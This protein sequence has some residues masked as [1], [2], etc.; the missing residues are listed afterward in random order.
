MNPMLPMSPMLTNDPDL[1]NK[2]N[3][4]SPFN[5][6]IFT[7]L[8]LLMVM[9]LPYLL[10]WYID[11]I[12]KEHNREFSEKYG[13]YFIPS[14]EKQALDNR[15]TSCPQTES[16]IKK[17]EDEEENRKIKHLKS[18]ILYEVK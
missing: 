6:Y 5:L 9:L 10:K 2:L 1:P 14:V 11:L 13:S 18:S 16:I 8:S 7:G 17:N 4:V 3:Q 15:G 12:E